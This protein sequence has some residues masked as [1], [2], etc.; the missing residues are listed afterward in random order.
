MKALR[1]NGQCLF[2]FPSNKLWIAKMD[3]QDF[4]AAFVQAET[5]TIWASTESNDGTF[6]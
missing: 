5:L 4:V 3:F 6:G 2:K 1:M